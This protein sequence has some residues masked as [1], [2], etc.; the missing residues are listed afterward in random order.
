MWLEESKEGGGELGRWDEVIKIVGLSRMLYVWGNNAKS[1]IKQRYAKLKDMG[2]T[3][4][5]IRE[6]RMNR[7]KYTQITY[8]TLFIKEIWYLCCCCCWEGND[9][10]PKNARQSGREREREVILV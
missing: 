4:N 6:K 9:K 1:E 2:A 3:D 5:A 7:E 8:Q 10:K